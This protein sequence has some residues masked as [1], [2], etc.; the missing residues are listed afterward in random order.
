MEKEQRFP[1]HKSC[2]CFICSFP[3]FLCQET[4]LF[5][6][7]HP[8]IFIHLSDLHFVK[9]Q[10]I[11]SLALSDQKPTKKLCFSLDFVIS[12]LGFHLIHKKLI[13]FF[14]IIQVGYMRIWSGLKSY[15]FSRTYWGEIQV[16][17]WQWYWP[18][19]IQS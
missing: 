17:W 9:F 3:F 12:H 18:K 6:Q 8:F 16:S 2:F 11:S 1:C 15:G 5:S 13:F 19:Q 14:G 4:F 7:P 10:L